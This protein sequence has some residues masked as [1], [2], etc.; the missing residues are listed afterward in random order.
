MRKF[1]FTWRPPKKAF[2]PAVVT[3]AGFKLIR[4]VVCL[5]SELEDYNLAKH[6]MSPQIKVLLFPIKDYPFEIFTRATSGSSLVLTYFGVKFLLRGDRNLTIC[7]AVQNISIFW[8]S[9]FVTRSRL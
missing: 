6:D 1:K 2:S 7:Y 8:Q 5:E 3:R 4:P 9:T